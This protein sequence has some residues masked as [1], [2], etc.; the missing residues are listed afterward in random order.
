MHNST[1]NLGQQLVVLLIDD[2]HNDMALF[3]LAVDQTDTP[4]WVQTALGIQQGIAYLEGRGQYSD[5]DLHPLPNLILLD[6]K[7][8]MGDGF[9]FLDWRQKFPQFQN[10]PVLVFSGNQYQSD[11]QRALALGAT[12]HVHKPMSYKELKATVREIWNYGNSLK[13]G[14]APATRENK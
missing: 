3:A 13:G 6:L 4:M 2:D 8:H 1:G 12:S 14:N 10:I 9:E 7:M 11:L 5:R